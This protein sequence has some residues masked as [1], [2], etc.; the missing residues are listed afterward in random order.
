[1]Y[2]KKQEAYWYPNIS[3]QFIIHLQ[4]SPSV[5][6]KMFI[7]TQKIT[8][9]NGIIIYYVDDRKGLGKGHK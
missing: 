2:L 6:E 9:Y 1:M 4:A 3:L 7:L 8:E 5:F